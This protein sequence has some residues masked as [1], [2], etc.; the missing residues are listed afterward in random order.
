MLIMMDKA[1]ELAKEHVPNA[2]AQGRGKG[3]VFNVDMKFLFVEL[4]KQFNTKVSLEYQVPAT[5]HKWK[6]TDGR[7]TSALDSLVTCSSQVDHMTIPRHTTIGLFSWF[8]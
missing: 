8:V 1:W 3:G 5:T 2:P 7:I 4:S 6:Q